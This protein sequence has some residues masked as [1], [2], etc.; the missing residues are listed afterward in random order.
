MESLREHPADAIREPLEAV[1]ADARQSTD[2]RRMALRVWQTNLGDAR[3]ARLIALAKSVE[4]GEL[5]AVLLNELCTLGSATTANESV[6]ALLLSK[7]NSESAAVRAAAI[8]TLA[9]RHI[10]DGAGAVTTLLR[11][12]DTRVQSAAAFA[13]GQLEVRSV[14]P[15]LLE[16]GTVTDTNLRKECLD[17]LRQLREPRVISLAVASVTDV[18]TELNAL[19]CIAEFGGP[20]HADLVTRAALRGTSLE[21]LLVSV[22]ALTKWSERDGID[23]VVRAVLQRSAREI[24]GQSGV[25]AGWRVFGPVSAA[26]AAKI[27]ESTDFAAGTSMFGAGPNARVGQVDDLPVK[28]G[29]W[30]AICELD[31]AEAGAAQL[32][33][34]SNTPLRVW[35]NGKSV[36]ERTEA[37]RFQPESDRSEATLSKGT[38]RV[39]VQLTSTSDVA[40]E[41]HAR[42]RRKSS[43]AEHERLVEAALSRPGNVERGRKLFLTVEKSQ[44]LKCHRLGEQ[45]EKI[46][47]ELTGIGSRF[48]RI[49][50][51]E[52][53]LDPSRTIAAGFQ[54]QTVALLDGRVLSGLKI[55]ETADTLVLVDNQGKKHS[56][57]KADIEESQAHAGSIMPDGLEK[58][59]T[60]DEFVDLIAFLTGEKQSASR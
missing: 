2:A 17:A 36:L 3:E 39:V 5:L 4:E 54:S 41:F 8:D 16:L 6:A 35:L 22:E 53:L 46:G 7:T 19:R 49:H 58:T 60:V 30:L 29:R 56:L 52:S 23:S 18:L 47:P 31:V 57:R 50:I 1:I 25:L 12:R 38:N 33:M 32:L 11:D 55:S 13:A 24:Q 44:C 43:K 27:V 40:W 26:E 42:L 37:R 10:A 15:T 28:D 51:I 14:I 59:L 21:A 20:E 45:G 48:S 34:S 9:R